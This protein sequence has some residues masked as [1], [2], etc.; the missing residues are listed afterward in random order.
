[1]WT[2]AAVLV[3]VVTVILVAEWMDRSRG[4]PGAS[5]SRGLPGNDGGPASG[6][7]ARMARESVVIAAVLGAVVGMPQTASA[8]GS[9][10]AVVEKG[11]RGCTTAPQSGVVICFRSPSVNSQSRDM[12]LQVWRAADFHPAP[13]DTGPATLFVRAVSVSAESPTASAPASRPV[14]TYLADADLVLPQ[15]AC[16]ED[17][18]FQASDGVVRLESFVS[19]CTP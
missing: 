19:A 5:R 7:G 10:G 12:F 11:F 3:G 4:S 16:R 8:A 1:M 18:R 14:L 9:Y 2:W 15:L 13:W 6:R 17:F